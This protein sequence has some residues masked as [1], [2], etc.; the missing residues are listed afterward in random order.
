ML[1]KDAKFSKKV[2]WYNQRVVEYFTYS[3]TLGYTKVP[4]DIGDTW[5]LDSFRY[6]EQHCNTESFDKREYGLIPW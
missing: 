3:D 1:N 5:D 2:Y 6:Y 4:N